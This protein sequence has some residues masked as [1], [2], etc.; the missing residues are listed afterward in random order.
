MAESYQSTRSQINEHFADVPCGTLNRGNKENREGSPL[1]LLPADSAPALGQNQRGSQL[2]ATSNQFATWPVRPSFC[3]ASITAF[4][5]N[6]PVTTKLFA[7][8]AAVLPVTPGTVPKA[9]FTA[10]THLP[11]HR[12]RSST[13][14]DF[15]CS[16][17]APVSLL[18]LMEASPLLP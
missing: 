3:R 14:S 4:S 5:L 2:P 9:L 6:S 8:L 17:L 18:T 15:T 16:S 13:L 12:C 11:H 10:F 1:P 7:P